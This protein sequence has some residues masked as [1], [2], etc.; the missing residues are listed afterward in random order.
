MKILLSKHRWYAGQNVR[1]TGYI[2]D[3]DDFL[4]EERLAAWFAGATSQDEME[5]ILLKANGQFAVII[6]NKTEIWAATDRLRTIPLFYHYGNDN[7][8]IGDSAYSVAGEMHDPAID[9]NA[10]SA[11][12]ATGYTLNDLTL[13][14]DLYQVEAGEMVILG[15]QI[16]KRFYF[17]YRLSHISEREFHV[18]AVD[19][20]NLLEGIFKSH[21]LDLRDR[22]IVIPLSGGYD[23]R[24][25]AA[26]CKKFHPDRVLCYTYGRAG[27]VEAA[28]AGEIAGRL[29]LPWINIVYDE[30]LIAGYLDD[31][32]FQGYYP[33]SSELGSMFFMQEYFAVKYLKENNKIPV[34]SVFIPGFSGDFL[35]GSHLTPGMSRSDDMD[36]VRIILHENFNLKK[37]DNSENSRYKKTINEKMILESRYPWL[38]YENWEMKERQAKFI[39]NS[40]G[41]YSYFGYDCRMPFWDNQFIDFC[42]SLPFKYKVNKK[43]YDHTLT[44]LIFNDLN[45]NLARELNPTRMDKTI[46]Q[47]KKRLKRWLPGRLLSLLISHKNPVLY[48]KIS[49][50]LIAGAGRE[51]F[52]DPPDKD[53]YNSYLAQWY[54]LGI[55]KLMATKKGNPKTDRNGE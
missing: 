31:P 29:Q 10:A 25:I 17:D 27:N 9:E 51:Y 38:K 35:A 53:N 47:I 42:N 39:T 54:L 36:I 48:D 24:L 7:I 41:V 26:M 23:S 49:S 22:F 21:F 40:A 55:R 37:S 1:V 3:G 12:L 16:K 4:A 8:I 52:N 2:R 13:L 19:L 6:E 30:K 33:Y 46:H 43:L 20:K 44:R 45:L 18:C 50:L 11:F 15:R 14:K 32:V 5:R 28:P 34:D